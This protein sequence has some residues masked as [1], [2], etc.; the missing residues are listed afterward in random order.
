[1]LSVNAPPYYVGIAQIYQSH[2]F[3][4]CYQWMHHH[5][6]LALHRSTSHTD[7]SH[8][9]S[10][11][12]TIFCWHCIDLP[13]TLIH[14]MLSVN[15]PPYFVGIA[16]TYQWHYHVG[17][18][19]TYQWHYNAGLHRPTCPITMLDCTDLPVTLPCWHCTDLP[20]ALQCWIVQ[21]YL[22]HYNVD[23]AQ[24]YLSHYH[25]DIVQTYQSR[26]L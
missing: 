5:I 2:W 10:E 19:Q 9:I 4:S 12:T 14:L 6:L 21:T 16:Q 3:T 11:C 15:A 22:S 23:I 25:V 8:V 17:I 26:G 20:V 24:T 1:M 7:S 18:A 13:V